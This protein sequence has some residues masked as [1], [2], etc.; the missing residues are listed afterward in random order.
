MRVLL[1]ED[2]AMIAQGLQTALRQGGFAHAGHVFDEQVAAREKGDQ[3][4]LDGFFLAINGFGDGALQLR[5]DLRGGGRHQ[6][7]T[8]YNPVTKVRLRC[9]FV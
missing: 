5:D 4:K 2:D 6:L 9:D 7:K 3:R 1:I 8:L